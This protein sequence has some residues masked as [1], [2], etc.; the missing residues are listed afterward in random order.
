MKVGIFIMSTN[1]EPSLTNVRMMK[2]T[3]FSDIHKLYNDNKLNHSYD[4]YVYSGD[5]TNSQN[6]IESTIDNDY[7][8]VHYETLP[9]PESIYRTYEKTVMCLN[10]H[11][12]YDFYIR[13]NISCFINIRLID[14]ILN[15][16]KTDSIYCNAINSYIRDDNYLNDLYARGDMMIFSKQVLKNIL[17]NSKKYE[18]CDTWLDKLRLNVEHVDDCLLG[19]CFIDAYGKDYYK[20]LIMTNYNFLPHADI[21]LINPSLLNIYSLSSRVKT[22]PPQY[23]YSGYSW[24][25]NEYRR[26]DGEK[27]KYLQLYYEKLDYSKET[28]MNLINKCT[29]K[30]ENS[31]PTLFV[32]YSN[33]NLYSRHWEFLKNKR[34]K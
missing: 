13:I 9:I 3:L 21:S 2:E 10:T 28:I 20:N 11:Q 4:I 34:S 12:D 15:G 17:S 25:D 14:R 29:V 26:L 32:Q 23:S 7:S 6:S 19:L 22:I 33:Q 8:F 31:R 30:K 16:L 18:Y 24:E 27:M 5:T 1:T